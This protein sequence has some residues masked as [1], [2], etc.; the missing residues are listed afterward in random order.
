[1]KLGLPPLY[2]QKMILVGPVGNYRKK[3]S[4]EELLIWPSAFCHLGDRQIELELCVVTYHRPDVFDGPFSPHLL[5]IQETD[6]FD[7]EI[8]FFLSNDILQEA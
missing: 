2:Y 8:L 6:I 1:M 3:D 7:L 5:D 4:P